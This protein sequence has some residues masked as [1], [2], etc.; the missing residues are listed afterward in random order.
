MRISTRI[1]WA[2]VEDIPIGRTDLTQ[3]AKLRDTL[4]EGVCQE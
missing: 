2:E 1:A 4:V 3:E